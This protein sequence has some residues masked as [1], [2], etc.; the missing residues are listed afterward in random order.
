MIEQLIALLHTGIVRVVVILRQPIC[1]DVMLIC[2]DLLTFI[3]VIY[4]YKALFL[5]IF[6]AQIC[7]LKH[8]NSL[9]PGES[10]DPS[11]LDAFGVSILGAYGASNF[12]PPP[13][14]QNRAAALA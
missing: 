13:H 8:Q 1:D 3:A 10:P 5:F 9:A 14:F 12:W 2:I 4:S 6:T 11:P 7:V